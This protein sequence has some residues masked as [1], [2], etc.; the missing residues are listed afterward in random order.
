MNNL[1]PPVENNSMLLEAGRATV[2]DLR[3]SQDELIRAEN[4]LANLYAAYLSARLNL[5]LTVGIIDTRPA[6]FWL[7]DP[8][9]D[10]RPEQRSAP[11]LRMPDNQVLP[12]ERFIEPTS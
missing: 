8:L 5:M 9:K 7:L 6:K 1:K 2:R 3:E 10:L 4:D 12:P 11:M